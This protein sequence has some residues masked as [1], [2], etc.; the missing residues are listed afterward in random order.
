MVRFFPYIMQ[1][2]DFMTQIPEDLFR[3]TRS[4]MGI[5]GMDCGNNPITFIDPLGLS[6]V[7]MGNHRLREFD[8]VMSN[9]LDLQ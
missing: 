2:T 5:I 8:T 6:Q 4:E 9:P 3:K 7:S 1:L